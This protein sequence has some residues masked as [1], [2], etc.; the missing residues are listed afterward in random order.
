[1]SK[2]LICNSTT[3]NATQE[4]SAHK[5]GMNTKMH[6]EKK[7]HTNKIVLATSNLGKIREISAILAPITCISQAAFNISP[8]LEN[9]QTFVENAII[10]A[11]H[12]SKL[13]HLPALADDSG[14]VIPD[15][16]Y[17]PGI[18]SAR[19]AG[20]NASDIDN[21][22]LILNNIKQQ[23]LKD[24]VAYF[25]CAIVLMPNA[26]SPNPLIA[27]GELHGKIIDTPQGKNGF[28]YDPIFYLEEFKCTLAELSQ[29]IKNSIS[30]RFLALQKAIKLIN[31]YM[32]PTDTV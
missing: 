11:R 23:G 17:E 21:I 10:K 16:N 2:R 8:A 30:H 28:G 27:T 24:P 14:L 26:S 12:V 7:S 3:K 9:G 32:D 25:Y 20:N 15:L 22:N 4:D 5:P 31:S 19:Y 6:F 13:T 18:F 1:M 29:T